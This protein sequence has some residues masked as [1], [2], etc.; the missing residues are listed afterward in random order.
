MIHSTAVIHPSAKIGKDVSIEPYAVIGPEVTLGDRCRVA[1][2]AVL[3]HTELGP[4]CQVFPHASLGLAPQHLGY[5]GEKTKLVVGARCV[6]RE[7]VTV[8]RGSLFDRGITTIGTDGYF[9]ATSHIAHDCQVGN[10]VILANGAT[11]AGHCIIG[12]Y[13]FISGMVGLHQFVRIGTGALCSGGAMVSRDV[14]P[15]CIAQ[16]DRAT[17]HGFNVVGLRRRG[18]NQKTLLLLKEAYRTVFLSNLSL[19]EAL[20]HPTLNI[21]NEHITL[22]REFF[23]ASKRSFIRPAEKTP[24][25]ETEEVFS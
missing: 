22:F 10:N 1:S 20:E 23:R 6:F 15:F 16:G 5:K 19:T 13:C 14:A 8:H 21:D 9:M 25:E 12:D 24:L 3:E 17:L 18:V 11:L 7:G 4:E 2:F